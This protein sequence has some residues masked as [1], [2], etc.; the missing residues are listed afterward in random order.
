[1][2]FSKRFSFKFHVI[3]SESIGTG[4]PPLWYIANAVAILVEELTNTSSPF[5]IPITL[6]A[7]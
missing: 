5:L 7:N 2:Y 4:I 6:H 3:G 1:M